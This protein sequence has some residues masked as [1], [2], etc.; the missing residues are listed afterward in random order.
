MNHRIV[1][2]SRQRTANAILA[3]CAI[4]ATLFGFTAN[5]FQIQTDIGT[6]EIPDLNGYVQASGA[7]LRGM[8]QNLSGQV[9]FVL[10]PDG[11][12]VKIS[13][14]TDTIIF[15]RGTLAKQVSDAS[16][17]NMR[18]EARTVFGEVYSLKFPSV[19][20]M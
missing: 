5:A 8:Q 10:I 14:F 20:I 18:K 7:V 2:S 15:S 3:V 9:L 6:L 4:G 17:E 1:F 16:F 12:M 11:E 13:D 19:L